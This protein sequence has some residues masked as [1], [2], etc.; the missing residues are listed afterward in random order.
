MVEC[1]TD[2]TSI[3]SL[4]APARKMAETHHTG[5]EQGRRYGIRDGLFQAIA[6]G[7]GE[8][9]L[10]AFALLFHATPVHLSLLSAIPQILGTWAQLVAV[11][12]SHW[13]SSRNRQVLWGTAGLLGDHPALTALVA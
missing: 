3:Q 7:G 11:K 12:V 10:S 1:G 4:R 13:F 9:Y 2:M 6:Q 8:Q 5:F